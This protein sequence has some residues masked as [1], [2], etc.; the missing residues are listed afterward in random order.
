MKDSRLM[1]LLALL[2]ALA[3]I[4]AACGSDDPVESATDDGG[5]DTAE[6]DTGTD[7]EP[8]DE[9]DEEP[10]SSEGDVE[11]VGNV[12]VDEE[13]A[14]CAS[15]VE[16]EVGDYSPSGNADVGM[17]FILTGGFNPHNNQAPA[18]FAYY[19]WLYEGLVRQDPGTGGIVPW[20]AK[21]FE[22]SDAG[23]QITFFL[24]E[25]VTFHDGEPFNAAAV[26]SNIEFIKTAGPPEVLPPVAGQMAA[27]D[28]VEA[29][30]DLTVQFNLNSPAAALV[31]SGLIRNSGF[32]VS[33]ASLGNAAA[34]PAGTGPYAMD[35]E[36]ADHTDINLVS[37]AD[38]W[39]PQM[40]GLE[41]VN[42]QG[43]LSPQVRLDGLIAGE[44]D[45]ATINNNEQELVPGYSADISVRI[46]FVVADWLGEQV[47]ALANKDVRCALAGTLNREG[48]V[49]QV[50][51][52]PESAIKQFAVSSSDYAYVDDLDS[53][54]FDIEAAKAL[55]DSTG[56]DPS[57]M[58]WSN[59]HLPGGFWPIT[60]S[61]FAGGMA[62][63]GVTMN[64]EALDPP[65]AGEMFARLARA[66][67][68][69]Q[70]V[71]YNEPNALMSLIARTG[72]G[73]LNPSKVSPDGVVELVNAAK[74]K[75]FEDGEADVAA[76]WKI[77]VEECIFI[78]NHA[79]FTTIGFQDYVT[80]VDHIQGV[81]VSFWPHG[82]R[83]DG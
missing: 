39:Q 30:D 64:N 35:S 69:L 28:S 13:A 17:G 63:L 31:L 52:V 53:P 79:L 82:V 40:V 20:L 5:T 77:M 55:F 70:I 62:E 74:S 38:Y 61:A 36:N 43:G 66:Q 48:I 56:V 11:D 67:H 37:F 46:G 1:R 80:G 8:A 29:V 59:G 47:P 49:G 7:D 6:T 71:A 19:G 78:I 42:I 21:C 73:G 10:D 22:I 65:G 51:Q 24:H 33:P 15:D 32:M 60:A 9:P 44:Y 4:A 27:V 72:E 83:V 75:S 57:E 68:P 12:E 3:M 76:A 18:A 50:G 45:I 41:T 2:L 26:V 14:N 34:T 23:D 25:G 58:V 54:D 16:L 81:P